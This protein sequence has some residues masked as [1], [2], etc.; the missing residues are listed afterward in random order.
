MRLNRPRLVLSL[1]LFAASSAAAQPDLPKIRSLGSAEATV[2][3]GTNLAPSVRVMSDGRAIVADF[4]NRR[5]MLTSADL[6]RVDTLFD[7]LTAPP[8]AFPVGVV[9]LV[10]GQGD[11][12]LFYD[13][14]ARGFRVLDPM[15]RVVRRLSLADPSVRVPAPNSVAA[16]DARGRLVIATHHSNFDRPVSGIQ[17]QAESLMV[18]R[19]RFD[20]RGFDSLT[21]MKGSGQR[22]EQTGDSAMKPRPVTMTLP[23]VENGDAWAMLSDGTVAIVRS[24][25]FHVDW[26]ATDGSRR[27]TPPIPWSW[28]SFTRA[29]RDSIRSLAE[30]VLIGGGRVISTSGAAAPPP[31]LPMTRVVDTVPERVPAFYGTA[32]SD[33]ENRFWLPLGARVFGPPS[34]D[35]VVYGIIDSKGKLVERVEL[36]ARRLIVGFGPDAVYAVASI[37]REGFA[38]ERYR[39]RKP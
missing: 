6:T 13:N 36:P 15:G 34:A 31:P 7:M 32:R 27:S 11:T 22:I 35:P 26:I 5:L 16:I 3:L 4:N 28:K 8:L 25:D 37:G 2:V 39:Y 38:L 10:P 23:A 30:T 18:A 33:H 20:Q 21:S 14:S 12:T 24:K 1:T 9:T 19:L 29:E 17:P